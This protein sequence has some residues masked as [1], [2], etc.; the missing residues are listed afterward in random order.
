MLYIQWAG[1]NN[2]GDVRTSNN[3]ELKYSIR[4]VYK[5]LP[6]VNHIY[7]LMNPPKKKPSWFNNSYS[8]F[9]TLVDQTETFPDIANTPS[10]NSNA[11]EY[12]I[13]NIKN[14][15]EHYI[16]FNDDFFIGKPLDYTYFFTPDGKAN[17]STYVK[18]K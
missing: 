9:V 11:I 5:N 2:T 3:N 8:D 4:S 12:T 15:N 1:E 16:Y 6:W 14:L 18:T 13:H 17:I 7:I 10:T